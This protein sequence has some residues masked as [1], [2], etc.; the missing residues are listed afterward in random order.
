L[1]LVLQPLADCGNGKVQKRADCLA[2]MRDKSALCGV[3]DY[4]S[5]DGSHFGDRNQMCQ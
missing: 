1:S 2:D 4:L 3:G 5:E